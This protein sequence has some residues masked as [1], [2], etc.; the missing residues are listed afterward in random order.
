MFLSYEL[1]EKDL[2][3]VY[4]PLSAHSLF[5]NRL[6]R[7]WDHVFNSTFDPSLNPNSLKVRKMRGTKVDQSSFLSSFTGSKYDSYIFSFK[8]YH[9]MKPLTWSHTNMRYHRYH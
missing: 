9:Q 3:H 7:I 2:I 8:N 1:C 6:V 5:S 4:D